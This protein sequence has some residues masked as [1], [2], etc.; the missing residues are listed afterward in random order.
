MEPGE[1]AR[2]DGTGVHKKWQARRDLNPQP[3]DLE[4]DALPLE[5]LACN[6]VRHTPAVHPL[7][8]LAMGRMLAA[9]AAVLAEFELVRRGALILGRGII[10]LLA[11]LAGKRD[12]DSHWLSPRGYSTISLTTPAPT[13]RPPSRIAKRSSFSMAIGVINSAVI[14]MLSPG[15][16]ISTPSANVNTPVTSVVRK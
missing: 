13:V 7:F 2:L 8:G 5:L 15:I 12:D 11:F 10:A 16:T 6:S 14:D 9:K 3:P 1:T 4:S